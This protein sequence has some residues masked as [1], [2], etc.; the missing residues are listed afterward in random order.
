MI[1]FLSNEGLGEGP[2]AVLTVQHW[3]HAS[4]VSRLQEAN[5]GWLTK[6]TFPEWNNAVPSRDSFCDLMW[7]SEQILWVEEGTCHVWF[8]R[9]DMHFV[10]F[11]MLCFIM[12]SQLSRLYFP[13]IE[14]WWNCLGF[15]S[16]T[17]SVYLRL[18]LVMCDYPETSSSDISSCERMS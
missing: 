11:I 10:C 18:V 8:C 13:K 4:I 15:M 6:G 12:F 14:Q 7:I 16:R 1:Y 2:A 3:K 17:W 9:R 5:K